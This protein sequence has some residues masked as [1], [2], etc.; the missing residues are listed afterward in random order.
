MY[1]M[2]SSLCSH[3]S[4]RPSLSQVSSQPLYEE[5]SPTCLYLRMR[6][7][8][9]HLHVYCTRELAASNHSALNLKSCM[10]AHML[11]L[12]LFLAANHV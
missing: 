8:C 7:A 11:V 9:Q 4:V 6:N 5:V 12:L 3:V 1:E 2:S 10:Q